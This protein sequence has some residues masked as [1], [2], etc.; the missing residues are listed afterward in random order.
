MYLKFVHY[1]IFTVLKSIKH[2]YFQEY[3]PHPSPM[4]SDHTNVSISNVLDINKTLN[5]KKK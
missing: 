1:K 2:T 3:P 4:Y 5:H